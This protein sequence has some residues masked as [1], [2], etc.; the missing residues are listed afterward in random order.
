MEEI[1]LLDA[2]IVFGNLILGVLFG[3]IGSRG[4]IDPWRS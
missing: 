3:Y 2:V 4:L 1:T